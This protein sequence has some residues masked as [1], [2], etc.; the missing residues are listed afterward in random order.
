MSKLPPRGR[1]EVIKFDK[2]NYVLRIERS[3]G[4]TLSVHMDKK[5]LKY[6]GEYI[7]LLIDLPD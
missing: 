1:A 6:L 4:K 3:D 2:D 5:E 7:L